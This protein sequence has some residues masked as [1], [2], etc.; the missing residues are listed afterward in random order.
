MS[1]SLVECN[2][3]QEVLDGRYEALKRQNDLLASTKG[4]LEG[5]LHRALQARAQPSRSMET[6][7]VF[8]MDIK[9]RK[10]DIKE[11]DGLQ[12]TPVQAPSPSS[13]FYPNPLNGIPFFCP[14]V[15]W[16]AGGGGD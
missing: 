6:I 15:R 5:E 11:I 4:D 8:P 9:T 14:S 3:Q 13:P 10:A 1:R 7:A 16:V 12:F 2:R